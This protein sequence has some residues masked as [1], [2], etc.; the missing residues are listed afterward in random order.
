MRYRVSPLVFLVA[1]FGCAHSPETNERSGRLPSYEPIGM[2]SRA[3]EP[4]PAQLP[5]R[6]QDREARD[7]ASDDAAAI[8]QELAATANPL[9]DVVPTASVPA[10]PASADDAPAPAASTPP[11]VTTRRDLE[12]ATLDVRV[13]GRIDAECRVS[14]DGKPVGP[15]PVVALE[16]P[17]GEAPVQVICSRRER[18]S[19]LLRFQ[20]GD[21]LRVV[22]MVAEEESKKRR[23]ARRKRRRVPRRR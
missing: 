21:Q 23:K 14:V 3:R 1:G 12:Y 13:S 19:E 18:F 8:R 9:V 22:V 4:A 20:P 6:A 10:E 16:V 5:E 15:T 17:L 11:S 7:A 2:A